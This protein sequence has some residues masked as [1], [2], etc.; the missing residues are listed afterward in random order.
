M[1]EEAG[2]KQYP[3]GMNKENQGCTGIE[4]ADHMGF[5]M[6][7]RRAI[8]M[9]EK[10]AEENRHGGGPGAG[11]IG[12]LGPLIHNDRVIAD[13]EARG[14]RVYRDGEEPAEGVVVIRAHGIP[15]QRQRALEARED[16]RVVDGTCPRVIRNQKKV[17]EWSRRGL[18]V[19]IA[20]DADHGE[21]V[22][23]A[24][25]A[26]DFS[27]VLTRKDV[28]GLNPGKPCALIAQTTLKAPEWRAVK[29]A[30][31]DRFPET[32][33]FESICGATQKRQEALADLCTRVDAVL[34]VGGKPSANTRRLWER[35]VE[36]GV[37]AWHI[38]G[39]R[40]LPGDISRHRRIGITAGASTPGWIVDEVEAAVQAKSGAGGGDPGGSRVDGE[41]QEG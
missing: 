10:V 23:L 13:M 25:Y 32:E 33:I 28:E 24:S 2:K 12:T 31:Q 5:C 21:I 40:E 27:I 22:S 37:A 30:V 35:A 38:T 39:A 34:V 7:V 8:E 6:G 19:I 4:R 16:L 3:W 29:E 26:S 17:E 18:H 36:R 41:A 1:V 15:R 14:I 11:A 20:G 9:T